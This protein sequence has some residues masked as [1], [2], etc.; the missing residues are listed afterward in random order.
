MEDLI[1]TLWPRLI[2]EV[3]VWRPMIPE[4]TTKM[5][6]PANVDALEAIDGV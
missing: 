6:E 3:A 5:R 4:P 1:V 2:K